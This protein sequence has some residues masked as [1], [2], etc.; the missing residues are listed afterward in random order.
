MTIS[1]TFTNDWQINILYNVYAVCYKANIYMII[2]HFYK[3][4]MY[5]LTA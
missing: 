2:V 1:C 3:V 4:G 5:L